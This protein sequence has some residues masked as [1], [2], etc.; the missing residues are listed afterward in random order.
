[1][2]R[3]GRR[4]RRLGRPPAYGL[5]AR[6]RG[7]PRAGP[8]RS[9]QRRCLDAV[10]QHDPRRGRA[11]ASGRP[12]AG[13]PRDRARALERRRDRAPGERRVDRARRPHRELPVRGDPLRRRLQPLLAGSL[14]KPPRRPR[15]SPGPLVAR[16]LRPR[17]PRGA[18]ERGRAAAV[19]PGGGR[20]RSL[21]VPAPVADA[22]LLAVPHR[23]DGARPADGDL[24]G[25]L[26]EVPRGAEIVEADDRKVW[27]F[28]GDGEMDEP[29]SMGAI[30]LAGRER[31]D[32]LVFV[33]NCNLQ[34]LDGPVRGTGRSSRSWRRTSAAPA[35]T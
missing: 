33:V 12:G 10:R 18:P 30:A 4:R 7:R 29:E 9:R 22:E 27:A 25:A 26:H 28:M 23:L 24:P 32:N 19:P 15:L 31:L 35:G 8:P 20:R 17:V 5:P 14:G 34:R 3:F 13:A 16:V 1:M 21:V 6:P 11:R 2:D